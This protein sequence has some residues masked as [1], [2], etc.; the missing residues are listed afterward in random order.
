MGIVFE[1]IFD[2]VSSVLNVIWSILCVAIYGLI[3]ISFNLFIRISELDILSSTDVS[4]IYQRVTMIL[5][6]IMV[7]YISFEFVKYV[8]QPDTF[9]DKEKGAGKLIYR[10][11]IAIILI[12]FVP[13]IFSLGYKVQNKLIKTQVFSKVILGEE[14]WD[15]ST[16]GSSFAADTFSAFYRVD[17]DACK[18][19]NNCEK[20]EEQVKKVIEGIKQEGSVNNIARGMLDLIDGGIEFKGF[21]AFIFGCFVLYI[22]FLYS[23]DVGVRYAQ[24]LFLQIIAPVAVISY[25]APQKDGMFKKWTKQCLTTYLDLFI[26]ISIIYFVLLVIRILGNSLSIFDM[27]TNGDS[28]GLQ[29]YIFMVLGLLIFAQRAPKM[30]Q[31]LFPSSGAASIG[32]GFSSKERFEPLGKSLTTIKKPIAAT[33]GAIAG[34]VRAAKSIRNGDLKEALKG[35]K[36][37]KT[38]A[39]FGK[40]GKGI[41]IGANRLRQ[42]NSGY[43]VAKAALKGASSGAK[44]GSFKE[45]ISAGRKS[46]QADETLM[47]KSGTP[48]GHDV[49]GSYYQNIK[50]GLQTQLDLLEARQKAKDTVATAVKDMKVMKTALSYKNDWDNKGIGDASAR[51]KAVKT[52]EKASRVYAVSFKTDPNA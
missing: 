1:T 44:N 30:I 27:T 18:V 41:S 5:T 52:I 21:F 33:A 13:T 39:K 43:I 22:L 16:Y 7:F 32:F 6:I 45:G 49:R 23:M 28:V 11:I 17:Y 46:V 19:L 20:S 47:S 37:P 9:G 2:L 29:V 12:A 24:L 4:S 3:K 35:I 34:T 31:E 36:E 42:L 51:E 48:L 38:I 15:Y 26:R 50:F 14:N 8:I 25:I 40:N 10:I